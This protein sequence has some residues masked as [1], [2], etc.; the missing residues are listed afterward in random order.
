MKS[1][2]SSKRL[3]LCATLLALSGAAPAFAQGAPAGGPED[4]GS[5]LGNLFGAQPRAPGAYVSP[6]AREL[7]PE[8]S[9]VG[10]PAN[11]RLQRLDPIP[12]PAPLQQGSAALPDL[13][14][15]PAFAPQPLPSLDILKPRPALK[16]DAK[17]SAEGASV[18]DGL[19]WRLFS[20]VPAL[21]GQLPLVASA[22]GGE[23]VFDVPEGDYVV[24]LAFGRAGLTK[25][26]RFTGLSAKETLL[27]DAGGLSLHAM[28][29]PGAP[30]ESPELDFDI[31]T[32]AEGETEGDLVASDVPADAVVRLNAGTYHVVSHYGAINAVVRANIHVD[33]GKITEATL[34]HH[35]AKLTLKLVREAGGEAMADTAWTISSSSGDVVRESVGAY[36]SLI[37]AAGDYEIVANNRDRVYQRV[38]TVEGGKDQEIEVTASDLVSDES[39]TGGSGDNGGSGD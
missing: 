25:R 10:V 29:G 13:P 7:V 31:Y 22:T 33:A 14:A 36:A 19:E 18:P 38:I 21:D 2:A 28:A 6:S 34:Q 20:A 23:A 8:D 4:G 15:L 39:G 30:I 24:H 9:E 32:L 3:V 16:L 37:L 11:R 26:I 17:L 35:A 27:L 1:L 5:F 12:L